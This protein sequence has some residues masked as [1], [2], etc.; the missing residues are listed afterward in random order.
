[1][2]LTVK[3]KDEIILELLKLTNKKADLSSR[4]GSNISNEVKAINHGW[5]CAL[6][7]VLKLYDT[8]QDTKEGRK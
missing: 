7:W 2:K 4:R 1:M 3:G 8:D 5:I 6:E